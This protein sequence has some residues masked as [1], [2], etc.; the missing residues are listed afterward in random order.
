[1]QNKLACLELNHNLPSLSYSLSVLLTQDTIPT[2]PGLEPKSRSP[3]FSV[4]SMYAHLATSSV[5]SANTFEVHLLSK[6]CPGYGEDFCHPLWLILILHSDLG[7]GSTLGLLPG[8]AEHAS[9]A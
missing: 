7:K 8:K 5:H 3:C 9:A 1:M 4:I 2:H 6:L